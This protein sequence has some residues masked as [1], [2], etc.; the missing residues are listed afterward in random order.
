MDMGRARDAYHAQTLLWV[1]V[2]LVLFVLLAWLSGCAEL[3]HKTALLY[4]CDPVAMETGYCHV[5]KPAQK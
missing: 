5:P 1:L 2:P 3:G 4:G